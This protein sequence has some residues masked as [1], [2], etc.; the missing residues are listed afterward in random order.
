MDGFLSRYLSRAKEQQQSNNHTQ[1]K[2][3]YIPLTQNNMGPTLNYYPV[4]PSGS[5]FKYSRPHP[6]A[7]TSYHGVL[8]SQATRYIPA[9]NVGGNRVHRQLSHGIAK[10]H[11]REMHKNHS[12]D[13]HIVMALG[14]LTRSFEALGVFHDCWKYTCWPV[15]RYRTTLTPEQQLKKNKLKLYQN[16]A[17]LGEELSDEEIR[18]MNKIAD[19]LNEAS[20]TCSKY[21]SD[22]HYCCCF[23]STYLRWIIEF[24]IVSLYF[25][26]F[27]LL[28]VYNQDSA[29][30]QNNADSYL[31]KA[32]CK[33]IRQDEKCQF[34]WA[35]ST[36][37][38]YEYSLIRIFL[39]ISSCI[40][41][42]F[43]YG[44]MER[45]KSKLLSMFLK[46][47]SQSTENTKGN[48]DQQKTTNNKSKVYEYM[49]GSE[50]QK[51]TRTKEDSGICF[52]SPKAI[53]AT[54][55][56]LFF[57]FFFVFGIISLTLDASAFQQLKDCNNN[58]A[59]WSLYLKMKPHDIPII[60]FVSNVFANAW[61]VL[62]MC[63][64]AYYIIRGI[65]AKEE[66]YTVTSPG[67]D[68][69]EQMRGIVNAP[70][71]EANTD[72]GTGDT[73]RAGQP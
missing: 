44:C 47:Y 10:E 33:Q 8:D 50:K 48:P 30:C 13:P 26:F 38:P 14:Y 7:F 29:F 27:L 57:V 39:F 9:R 4:A 25:V 71:M 61:G 70:S 12:Q 42:I 32:G 37:R 52:S 11:I 18:E 31:V 36:L 34:Q 6:I 21:I 59:N 41:Y 20:I 17:N 51:Y 67:E 35:A 54:F 16:R 2:A 46:P 65:N 53:E 72:S 60:L 43:L 45:T 68:V 19:E 58:D 55:F 28:I 62:Y 22:G 23:N 3:M 69:E 24:V 5:Y 66:V 63:S 15:D 40:P 1:S 56:F 73:K 49:K 64:R